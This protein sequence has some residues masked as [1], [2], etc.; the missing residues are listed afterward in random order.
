MNHQL[1]WDLFFAQRDGKAELAKIRPH[2]R[3]RKSAEPQTA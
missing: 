1:R 2:R 3:K